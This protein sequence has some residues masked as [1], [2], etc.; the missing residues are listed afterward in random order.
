LVPLQGKT[1][2]LEDQAMK[3]FSIRLP[4]LFTLPQQNG[5]LTGDQRITAMKLLEALLREAMSGPHQGDD[6]G[7]GEM[8][9]DQD[10]A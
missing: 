1:F 3:Q 7:E 2:S 4:D 10:H 8:G 6:I 5:E 9:D